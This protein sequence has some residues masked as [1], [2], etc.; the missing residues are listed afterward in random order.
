MVAA[1]SSA[2]PATDAPSAA[3]STAGSDGS[4]PNAVAI[5]QDPAAPTTAAAADTPAPSLAATSGAYQRQ[6][7]DA[8]GSAALTSAPAALPAAA[9]APASQVAAQA[10]ASPAPA[11]GQSGTGGHGGS[12]AQGHG[13]TPGRTAAPAPGP[14]PTGPGDAS[15][16]G[17]AGAPG[18]SVFS[19][20][21]DA[22]GTTAGPQPSAPAVP[23][24]LARTAVHLQEAVDA[25]RATFTAVNAAGISTAR[26]SLKP[27]A[28]GGIRISLSQ[29]PDGL[30]ARV[31]T[32]HPEAAQA[33]QQSAADLRRT[34]EASGMS[35][36]RLD[37]GGSG[38]QALTGFSGSDQNGSQA[39]GGWSG[40]E[41]EPVSAD[42]TSTTTELTIE[43]PN[44][45]LVNV[46]V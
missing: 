46:L 17:L 16:A 2:A 44:G 7:A 3:D 26:I 24:G 22:T 35:L 12:G 45:S 33:L 43:L 15:T 18:S 25:V 31:A 9:P 23:D 42:E 8:G 4:V 38:Q 40:G 32:D 10:S 20:A 14:V 28:L 11:P 5:A 34:L 37:I 19:V 13:E 21:T 1:Q 39:G 27:E 36:L 41:A 29:T 30:V 6:D